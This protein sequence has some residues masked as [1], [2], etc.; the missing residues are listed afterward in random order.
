MFLDFASGAFVGSMENCSRRPSSTIVPSAGHRR[1]SDE[2]FSADR[3]S[4]LG[5]TGAYQSGWY[6]VPSAPS[7]EFPRRDLGSVKPTSISGENV[8]P[9]LK[10]T[11]GLA[12]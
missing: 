6:G 8:V 12:V 7:R 2:V 4:F 9:P 11:I 10:A 3:T 1:N 5:I